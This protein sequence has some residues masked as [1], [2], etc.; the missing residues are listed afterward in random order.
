MAVPGIS[1]LDHLVPTVSSIDVTCAFYARALGCEEVRFGRGRRG[2][3]CGSVRINLRQA[4]QVVEPRAAAPTPGSAD[5]CFVTVE[6]LN[7]IASHLAAHD[8]PIILGPVVRNGAKGA[9]RSLY[10]REPDGN[11]IEIGHYDGGRQAR[12]APL[13]EGSS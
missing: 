7:T 9:M 13:S 6:G 1:G 2:L 4:E 8:I 5:L 3:S 12:A 11:L 10:F